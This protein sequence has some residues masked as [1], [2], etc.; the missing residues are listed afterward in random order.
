MNISSQYARD[1]AM[2]L[3]QVGRRIEQGK[4]DDINLIKDANGNLIGTFE[5]D[6][7]GGV[8]IITI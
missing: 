6:S 4:I 5:V 3:D 2:I 1:A 8:S 7:S